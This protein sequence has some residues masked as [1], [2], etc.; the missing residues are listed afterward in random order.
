[1]SFRFHQQIISSGAFLVA[2]AFLSLVSPLAGDDLGTTQ[3]GLVG[4]TVTP[5]LVQ[6]QFG[7]LTLTNP[8]GTCSA[9][10]L[11]DY[12]AITAA[13]CV[14]SQKTP[15]VAFSAAQ[16]TLSANWPSNQKSLQAVQVVAFSTGTTAANDIALL[17]TGLYDFVRSGYSNLTSPTTRTLQPDAPAQN[18]TVA[19]YGRGINA[20]AYQS[21]NTPVPSQIDGQYR[22]AS[23][24]IYSIPSDGSSYSYS[25]Q[26]GVS[27][28]GGDS[29]GPS[30]I[31]VWD[32]PTSPSRQLVWRLLGVH[33]RCSLTCLAGQSCTPPNTWQWVTSV[34]SCTDAAVYPL[35]NA[36]NQTIQ[37]V[38]PSRQFIG[39]FGT[40]PPNSDPIF[41]YAVQ[42]DGTLFWYNYDAGTQAWRGPQAVGSGWQSFQNVFSAGGENFDAIGNDGLL[43]WYAHDG[44]V[45]GTP[46]WE[47]PRT[48]GT[49][50]NGFLKVFSG[51]DGIVYAIQP[52]GTLLWYRNLGY[53]NGTWNWQGPNVVGQGWGNFKDVFSMGQGIIYAVQ[54]DGTLLW[55]NHAGYQTGAV[56]WLGPSVVG[57]AWQNFSSIVPAGNGVIMAARP[58]GTLLWYKHVNYL[59]GLSVDPSLLYGPEP[60][61]QWEGGVQ[62]GEGWSGFVRIFAYLPGMPQ[63]IH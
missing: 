50:W 8:E 29:G 24:G 36:I 46:N 13:H 58:D 61:A 19:A 4:G 33:S 7:L 38:P 34:S 56:S 28:A 63:Q 44:F 22:S 54:K 35:E 6:E 57:S 2:T 18:E 10:M 49:R 52:D 23:F 31:Q 53:W 30:L 3:Q 47:G 11:N 59:Q 60:R 9:S 21:L 48:V 32:D 42:E 5:P 15:G 25:G 20:F 62:V 55:Y 27:V 16:I 45:D 12:W 51:S 17:Q 14:Y 1:M 37:Q 41:L 43:T 26:Y 39:S 40:T